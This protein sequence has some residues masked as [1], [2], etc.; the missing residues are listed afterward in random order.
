[1][2]YCQLNIFPLQLGAG[3]PPAAGR[4]VPAD[5]CEGPRHH[6]PGH[7][8]GRGLPPPAGGDNRDIQHFTEYPP[9]QEVTEESVDM[10]RPLRDLPQIQ[11]PLTRPQDHGL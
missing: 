9:L 7:L 2:A 6:G 10:D 1:M 3:R 11:L 8:P 5:L 4:R